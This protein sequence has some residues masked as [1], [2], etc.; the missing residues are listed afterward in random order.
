MSEGKPSD[1]P[2]FAGWHYRSH[3]LPFVRRVELLWHA[4]RAIGI[5]VF[6]SPAMA[7]TARS[8]FFGLG[9]RLTS[10]KLGL[11]NQQVVCLSR[12]VLH[13]TYRGAG[14]AAAFIRRACERCAWPWVECVAEMGRVNPVFE[15]AGFVRLG[16]C[17]G[18]RSRAGHSAIYCGSVR[19][20][21]GAAS[22]LIT[23]ETHAKSEHAR[24]VYYLFDNRAAFAQKNTTPE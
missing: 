9:G 18:A 20:R 16:E 1:W 17:G 6:G 7:L 14:I 15:R 11:L 23:A 19:R 22:K 3:N 2:Q 13:P 8:K 4:D 10:A 12:V 24:P 21:R 5:C